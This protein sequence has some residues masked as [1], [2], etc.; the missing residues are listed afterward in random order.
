MTFLPKAKKLADI[1][2]EFEGNLSWDTIERVYALTFSDEEKL[3]LSCLYSHS[4]YIRI[5]GV[6]GVE[7]HKR[8]KIQ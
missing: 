5:C 6:Y 7:F 4:P 3:R 8:G 2:F 1:G